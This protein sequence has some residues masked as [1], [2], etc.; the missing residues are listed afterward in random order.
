[1]VALI[2]TVVNLAA[3]I[4]PYAACGY[5]TGSSATVLIGADVSLSHPD[6]AVETGDQLAALAPDGS[7][8]GVVTWD[9]D[10]AA[11]TVWV[12]DPFTEGREGLIPGEPVSLAIW[13]ASSGEAYESDVLGA[14]IKAPFGDPDVFMPDELYILEGISSTSEATPAIESTLALEQNYPNPAQHQTTLEFS[15]DTDGPV[16]I[17]VFDA[18]GRRVAMPLNAKLQAGPH[19]VRLDVSSLASGAYIYRLLTEDQALQRRMTVSR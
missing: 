9:G 17:E 14:K 16:V 12:D 4:S 15:L 8:A 3:F 5:P 10:G 6:G 11:L 1:M 13:D 18:L 2:A 19:Q 7:C